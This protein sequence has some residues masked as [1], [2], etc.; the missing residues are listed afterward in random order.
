MERQR[1]LDQAGDPGGRI[2]CPRLVLTEPSAQNCLRLCAEPEGLGQ[3]GHFDRVAERGGGAVRLDVGDGS[4][5][6]A[7]KRMGHGD[8]FRLAFDARRAEADA[9]RAVVVERGAVDHGI[10]LVAVA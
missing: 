4:R 1:R 6:D 8:D 7:G 5:I 3:R 9:L 10:D 2:R